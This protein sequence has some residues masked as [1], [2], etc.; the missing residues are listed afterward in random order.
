MHVVG[1]CSF[2]QDRFAHAFP[3]PNLE[4]HRLKARLIFPDDP[5][6]DGNYHAVAA[7]YRAGIGKC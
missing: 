7:R 3:M 1:I 5:P 4:Q 2:T 6:V